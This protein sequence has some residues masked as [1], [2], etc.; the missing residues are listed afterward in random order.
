MKNSKHIN[1]LAIVVG[2]IT[3]TGISAFVNREKQTKSSITD[4]VKTDAQFLARAAEINLEEIQLAQLAQR[5]SMMT[6]VK[7]LGERMEK[8]HTQVLSDLTT[9]A[10]KKGIS[11]P[12]SVTDEAN[13]EYKELNNKSNKR[14]NEEYCELVIKEH[15]QAISLFET[16]S[17]DAKDSE[18]REWAAATLPT[19]R[20]HLD[21][22]K[23]CKAKCEKM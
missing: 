7:E 1:F 14:F 23:M 2:I 20:S 3:F 21:Q 17:K 10:N 8:S 11:L 9:L 4:Y 19:L 15:K 12:T 5:K 6:D 16:A 13:E 22:S 18:I